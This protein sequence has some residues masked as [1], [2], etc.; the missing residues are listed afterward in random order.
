MKQ[1]LVIFLILTSIQNSYACDCALSSL[2]TE[3]E[4]SAEIFQGKV[5]KKEKVN[6]NYIYQFEVKN[7]WKGTTEVKKSIKTGL[8]GG[9]CGVNFEVG[10][11]YIVFSNNGKTN[12]CKRTAEIS[13]TND[14][15]KLN[16]FFSKK[17][18]NMSFK[19]NNKKLDAAESDY[20][21]KEFINRQ[22]DF[23]FSG[24]SIAFTSNTT[25][26]SKSLWFESNW[27]HNEPAVQLIKLTKEEKE[28]LGYDAILVTWCKV[29]I[30]KKLRKRLIE[31]LKTE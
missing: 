9:D 14:N 16:Y 7:V 10:K 24:K 26:I 28:T 31:K 22:L 8:G 1:L 4:R 18:I 5:L 30:T 13:E 12:R 29:K 21:N 23:D 6:H 2:K 20:L 27:N 3:I 17:S 15:L 19:N 25:F 11:S